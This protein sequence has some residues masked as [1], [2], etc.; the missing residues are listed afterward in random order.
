MTLST[1]ECWLIET[2]VRRRLVRIEEQRAQ[3][4]GLAPIPQ[5]SG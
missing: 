2:S 4:Q 3:R 1:N 5:V